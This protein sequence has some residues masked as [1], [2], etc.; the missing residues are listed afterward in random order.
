MQALPRAG[1]S[2][3]CGQHQIKR[4]SE[5]IALAIL[6]CCRCDRQPITLLRESEETTALAVVTCEIHLRDEFLA[7]AGEHTE[8]NVRGATAVEHRLY[9]AEAVA[10]FAIG[11]RAA[12]A[13]K[14]ALGRAFAI[15]VRVS[16]FAGRIDL[17]DFD[18]RAGKGYAVAAANHA[19]D[20]ER[21]ALGIRATAK[22]DQVGVNFALPFRRIERAERVL[23]C[24][25][26]RGAVGIA[27]RWQQS[28]QWQRGRAGEEA[29][30]RSF[31]VAIEV[32]GQESLSVVGAWSSCGQCDDVCRFLRPSKWYNFN[33]YTLFYWG[34]WLKTSKVDI[35]LFMIPAPD[36]P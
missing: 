25:G 19:S 18:A 20:G 27:E 14:A 31:H 23:R 3:S 36:K 30:T 10:A 29:A 9:G 21:R 26:Q 28:R 15:I 7:P 24:C 17:P 2:S 32:L 13:L 1:K 35:W 6:Q 4:R 34:W 8:V 33:V 5:S 22:G 16:V 12:K 11:E